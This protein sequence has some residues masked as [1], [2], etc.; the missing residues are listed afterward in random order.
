MYQY[1]V[2]N[3][4]IELQIKQA[5]YALGPIGASPIVHATHVKPISY[6]PYNLLAMAFDELPSVVSSL[7]R[8]ACLCD[9]DRSL[10]CACIS[11]RVIQALDKV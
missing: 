9:E 1:R 10:Q 8:T 11:D 4:I 6:A 5:N 2:T 3:E 7:V